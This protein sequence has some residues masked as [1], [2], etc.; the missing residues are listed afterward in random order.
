M[1]ITDLE[2]D[3][4]QWMGKYRLHGHE[5]KIIYFTLCHLIKENSSSLSFYNWSSQVSLP[6]LSADFGNMT[7]NT[8][9][10]C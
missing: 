4:M 7:R 2:V 10:Y 1:L 9:L 6:L 8:I 3:K 5:H